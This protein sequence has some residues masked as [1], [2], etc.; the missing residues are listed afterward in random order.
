MTQQGAGFNKLLE[1]LGERGWVEHRS[2]DLEFRTAHRDT[3]RRQAERMARELARLKCGVVFA[4]GTPAAL[5]AHAGAPNVP[6]VFHVGGDP[7][8]R[9]GP[10]WQSPAPGVGVVNS[11]RG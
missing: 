1:R 4:H 6:M 3:D 8:I 9:C 11:P 5:A 10:G 2:L 7:V